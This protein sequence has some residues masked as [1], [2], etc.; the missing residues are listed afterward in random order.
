MTITELAKM[1]GLSRQWVSF[2]KTRPGGAAAIA[3]AL[4]EAEVWALLPDPK[5]EWYRFLQR[6]GIGYGRRGRPSC[7]ERA[8]AQA[9]R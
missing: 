9:K 5:A 1:L 2:L 3:R 8:Q 7:Q 6:Q 4:E